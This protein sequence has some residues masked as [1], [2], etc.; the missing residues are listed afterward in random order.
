[1]LKVLSGWSPH[2]EEGVYKDVRIDLHTGEP[3][4]AQAVAE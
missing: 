4:E 2:D 3:V 1:V